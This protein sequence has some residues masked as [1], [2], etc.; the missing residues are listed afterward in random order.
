[1][2]KILI[3]SIFLELLFLSQSSPSNIKTRSLD[4]DSPS[5]TKNIVDYLNLFITIFE[6]IE[7]E[8]IFLKYESLCLLKQFQLSF[9]QHVLVLHF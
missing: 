4:E 9:L 1:M 8:N 6:S 3:I 5:D 2:K 7:N